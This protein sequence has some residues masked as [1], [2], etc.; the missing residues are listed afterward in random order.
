MSLYNPSFIDDFPNNLHKKKGRGVP[1]HVLRYKTAMDSPLLGKARLMA[2]IEG[3]LVRSQT[4]D[5][6]DR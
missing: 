6:M 1:S 5:N 2:L 4:S 3:S